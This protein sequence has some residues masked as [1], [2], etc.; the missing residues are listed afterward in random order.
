MATTYLKL[1]SGVATGDTLAAADWNSLVAT[2]DRAALM[3]YDLFAGGGVYSGWTMTS[4][5]SYIAAGYGQVGGCWCKTATSQAISGLAAGTVYI[6]AKSDAGSAASGTVDF[7]SRATSAAITNYDSTTNAV[8]LGKATYAAGTG[9]KALDTTLRA[10][11]AIA[12]LI[13][14]L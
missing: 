1:L 14:T 3:Q 10:N 6:F 4:G 13:A 11:H 9:L 2:Q 12:R 5:S 8:C 7:V